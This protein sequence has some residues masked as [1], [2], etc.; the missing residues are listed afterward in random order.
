MARCATIAPHPA[1]DRRALTVFPELKKIKAA[2]RSD[3]RARRA[4]R[5]PRPA[6]MLGTGLALSVLALAMV[7]GMPDRAAAQTSNWTGAT[8][9]DWT[10][11]SNWS[12]GVPDGSTTAGITTTTPN[13]TVLGVA[14]AATGSSSFLDLGVN[15]TGSLTIQNG[16]TLTTNRSAILGAATSAGNATSTV[17][18]AGSLWTIG[19]VLQLG[20]AQATGALTISNQGAVSVSGNTFV[21]ND[22]G[23]GTV[24]IQSGG[25]LTANGAVH[26]ADETTAGAGGATGTVTVTGAGS[27]LTANNSLIVGDFGTGTLTIGTGGMVTVL[28]G[29]IIGNQAGSSGTLNIAGG[30]LATNALSAGSGTAQANFNGATLQALGNNTSFISGFSG[31]ALNIQS[32]GL[33]I[34]TGAFTVGTDTTSAFSGVGGL[35]KI[36]SRTL[37]LN[38]TNA[39][40]G[41]TAINGGTLRVNGSI[42]TSS[43]TTVNSGGTLTG[44]G[45]VG[46]TQVAAGGTFAPGSS[47]AASPSGGTTTVPGTSMTVAGNLA[48]QSG[49]LYVVSVNASTASFA[50]VTGTAALAGTV[51]ANTNGAT[52]NKAYDILHSA[53]LNGTTFS[54]LVLSSSNY[55]GKLIYSGTDV[56]LSLT[57][58][59]G[60]GGGSSGPVGCGAGLSGNQ[61]NTAGALNNFFNN[62]GTLP[63]SFADVF[64]L[65][66]TALSNALSHLD[67]EVA[68][69]AERAAFQLTNQFLSVMLDPFVYGRSGGFAGGGGG[70][71][72]FAPE[73][74]D[75]LPPDVALA[76]AA[77]LN[78]SP[79]PPV[80]D[81]RWTAWGAAYGGSSNTRGDQANAGSNNLTANTY[82]F[83]AGMDYHVTPNALFGFALAGAGTN[84]G[85]ANALGTGRSDALQAGV[86]GISW[87]GPAYVAGALSFTNH[88]FTTSRS[89]LGDQMN[90]SFDGQSYGA[91][92][93]GGYRYAVWPTLGVTP[94]GAVQLQDFHTQAY[95]ESDSVTGGFALSYPSQNAA[96]VRTEL[97]SRLDAPTLLYGLP[98]I[99]R[100]RLAWA[101]DFVNNPALN[102]AFE[103]LPGASFTVNGAQIPHDSAL[104]TAGAELFITPRWTLLAKFDGEFANGSQTYTGS[105]TLSYTW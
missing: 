22:S 37:V 15:S 20:D 31:T 45:T 77:I 50:N 51:Q 19:Q 95:N 80:F 35:T 18:G 104:T 1:I 93:E 60:G 11:A 13:P 94:Y 82:G 91:R 81:Q 68:T 8:S 56:Y 78:K 23:H 47:G 73:Q 2:R 26:I 61:C 103:S 44:T 48:F 96:D 62:G 87:F 65:T 41:P 38:A 7:G 101:H 42:A 30:T 102:P 63:Q 49:A 5:T 69:G 83:A 58:N 79:A 86:Y 76:Y 36:G 97:G 74:Q 57:A 75:N 46:S 14:G 89:A 92:I 3:V 12:S 29:T 64:S 84:W 90:A 10:N 54:G 40:T 52:T 32:G 16:S 27:Q 99:L 55:A 70:A 6:S 17:T 4:K 100:G 21:G 39:Y 105:G 66:G 59:L 34:N 28:N 25:T 33:T 53:G 67:G 98:L 24:T 43:L 9:S 72:G 85:L 71:I 88:W